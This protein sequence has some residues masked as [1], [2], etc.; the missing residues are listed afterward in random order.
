MRVGCI[1]YATDQGIGH[2]ARSFYDAGIITDMLILRHGRRP[3]HPEWYRDPVVVG[4][5]REEVEVLRRFCEDKD[6]MLF[7][8]TP[9]DWS[10]LNY[11]REVKV[12]TIIVPMYE[13]MPR[14]IPARPD[15][16][17]CPSLLDIQYYP[18]SQFLEVPVDGPCPRCRG[19]GSADEMV[20]CP[21]C[22]GKPYMGLRWSQ[23]T[24]AK[25]FLHNSGHI[26]LME[27]KGTTEILKAVEFIKSPAEITIRSQE[28]QLKEMA[29]KIL[30]DRANRVTLEVGNFPREILF[31]DHDVFLM[32]EKYNG[33]SLPLR[34]A[35]ASGMLV[36]TSDR[37]PMNEWLPTKVD[38]KEKD[39][40]GTGNPLIPVSSYRRASVSP[41]CNEFDEAV[42][43]PRVIAAKIDEW[44]GRDISE[45]SRQGQQWAD[46]MSWEVLGPKYRELLEGLVKG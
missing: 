1:G 14:C 34:E 29:R 27:H 20:I 37:F 18:E 16:F 31:Q 30:G 10:L 2:L 43:D 24:V 9:F 42:I 15:L 4:S 21:R 44:Y 23:R 5:L 26:G 13:C 22:N 46:S 39:S 25:R 12:K 28:P 38:W 45:Y 35:R 40:T 19:Y 7:F 6:V 36:M 11:C 32:A 17:L 3:D 33:L 41:R 8:E